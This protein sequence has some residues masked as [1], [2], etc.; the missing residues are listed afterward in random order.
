MKETSSRRIVKEA[1]IGQ[2]GK[3]DLANNA[4]D[5]LSQAIG[6]TPAEIEKPLMDKMGEINANSKRISKQAEQVTSATAQLQSQTK[7][8]STFVQGIDNKL[9]E[10]GDLQNWTEMLEREMR[11]LEEVIKARQQ[12]Q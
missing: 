2:A 10:M 6:A 4:S 1:G 12:Q 3:R 7:Q 9:K 8:L 5:I 11:V